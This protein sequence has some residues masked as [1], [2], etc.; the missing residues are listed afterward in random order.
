[1]RLCSSRVFRWIGGTTNH[2]DLRSSLAGR[3][4]TAKTESNKAKRRINQKHRDGPKGCK[5]GG[6]ARDL[7][8]R[9]CNNLAEVLASLGEEQQAAEV[10]QRGRSY[11]GRK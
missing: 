11:G 9:C 10:L 1:M 7:L 4:A 6:Y 5:P 3:P 8:G 2:S